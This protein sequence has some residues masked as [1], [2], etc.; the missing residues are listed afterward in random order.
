MVFAPE[1]RGEAA[2]SH[3]GGWAPPPPEA[4]GAAGQVR[5]AGVAVTRLTPDSLGPASPWLGFCICK[6]VCR[7]HQ[8]LAAS[9]LRPGLSLVQTCPH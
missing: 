6:E 7:A 1:N 9:P 8:R 4:L 5:L 3:S 2:R